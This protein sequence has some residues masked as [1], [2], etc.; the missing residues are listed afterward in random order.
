MIYLLRRELL[1]AMRRR[2]ELINPLV[3]NVMVVALFPLAVTPDMAR[4]TLLAP[5]ILWVGALLATLLSLDTLFRYD[6]L[7]GGLEQL[8]T[9]DTSLSAA[10]MAKIMCYWC[11]TGLPL[12]LM[13]P[14]LGMMLGLPM[15]VM[16]V[17]MLTLTLGTLAFS[18]IGSIGAALVVGLRRGGLLLSLLILPLYIPVLIFGTGA[19]G[20]ATAGLD[21][22][23]PLAMTGAITFFA[24]ALSPWVAAGALRLSLND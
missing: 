24:L 8:A 3:F 5:G 15:A 4:L 19:I 23:A 10:V 12:T 6:Y 17:T 20:A 11:F 9:R 22:L 21:Y 2:A 18:C 7:D 1:L 14:L 16:P 13:S